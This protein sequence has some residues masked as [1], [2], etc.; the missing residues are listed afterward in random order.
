MLVDG[1]WTAAW[2]PVQASDA[3]GGFLRQTSSFRNWVTPDGA[4]GPTG[5]GGFPADPGALHLYAGADLPLGL[6]HI[7]RAQAATASR[8]SRCGSSSPR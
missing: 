8:R 3:K 7:D 5:E 2:Q 4:A 6:A 1:R